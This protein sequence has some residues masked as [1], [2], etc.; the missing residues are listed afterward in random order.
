MDWRARAPV[1]ALKK[2]FDCFIGPLA[3]FH[4]HSVFQL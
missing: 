4:L 2:P 1:D 3:C